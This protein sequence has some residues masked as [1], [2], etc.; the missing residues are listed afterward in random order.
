MKSSRT[1][2]T[3]KLIACATLAFL[4]GA[5]AAPKPLGCDP[6]L[7]GSGCFPT[8]AD[9]PTEGLSVATS[10][11]PV[12]SPSLPLSTFPPNVVTAT[13][14]W[15]KL[16]SPSGQELT[17]EE[18]R[19][20]HA[21]LLELP[22]FPKNA[23]NGCQAR[24]HVTYNAIKKATSGKAYKAW[25]F[26]APLLTTAYGGAISYQPAEGDPTS[27]NFHVAAAYVAPGGGIRVV[28]AL[29]SSEP[30]PIAEW[31]AKFKY[32]GFA[33]LSFMDGETYTYMTGGSKNYLEHDVISAVSSYSGVTLVSHDGA[34][35]IAA[36][37]L[38]IAFADGKF[39]ECQW[40]SRGTNVVA[41]INDASALLPSPTFTEADDN[42]R[43][44]ECGAYTKKQGSAPTPNRTCPA[45]TVP[46]RAAAPVGCSAAATLFQVE[47][48]RWTKQGL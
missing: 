48:D 2:E 24:A 19:A 14:V 1:P 6:Q 21:S 37:A 23:Y 32:T 16:S 7:G 38:A 45:V 30:L 35:A 29:A 43:T 34:K 15:S 9:G 13:P 20:V 12:P 42:E 33:V 41:L 8:G 47:V 22:P 28:D 39:A 26:A 18:E 10:E 40:K 4:V 36:D 11:P 27:W 3:A 31:V 5:C 46:A 17:T 44:H 25:L